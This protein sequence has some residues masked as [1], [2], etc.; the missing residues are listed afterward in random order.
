MELNR[1]NA[2]GVL[3][4]MLNERGLFLVDL[5]ISRDNDVTVTVESCEGVVTLDDCEALNRLFTETF[6]QDEEDYSLTVTS[7]GLDSAFKVSRQY[8]KAKGSKVE[9][10]LKGGKKVIG[11]LDAHSEEGTSVDGT[12][13]PQSEINKV[14][15]HIDF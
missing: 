11:V 8:E 3:Q 4:D 5:E 7:A 14:K 10:W 15:Y 1:T 6:D 9:M 12:L 2:T 13:Y